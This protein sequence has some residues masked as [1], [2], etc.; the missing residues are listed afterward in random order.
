MENNKKNSLQKTAE[1]VYQFKITL[2]EI[3]PPIW[4]RII[5]PDYYTFW[6]LSV[7]IQCAMGWMGEHLHEFVINF[8]GTRIKAHLGIPDENEDEQDISDGWK[9]KIKD[10]FTLEN[11]TANYVYDFGDYW[12]HTVMLEK[13]I[14]AE[15]GVVCTVCIAG[16]RACPPEDCGGTYGYEEIINGTSEFQEEYKDYDPEYFNADDIYF[17]DPDKS[18]RFLKM[19]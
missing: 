15:K 12:Q 4:R 9:Y 8:P 2:K 6:D 13:I 10:F 7:A 11:N 3:K 17:E 1:N 16:K 18:L 19:Q 5:V 14:P